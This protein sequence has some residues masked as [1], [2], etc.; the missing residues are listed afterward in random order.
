[1]DSPTSYS[2]SSLTADQ[3]AQI[4]AEAEACA[5]GYGV[6]SAQTMDGEAS[7]A[8][9]ARCL[10]SGNE[11]SRSLSF[12]KAIA[13]TEC[14]SNQLTAFEER[15]VKLQEVEQRNFELKMKEAGLGQNSL[16]AQYDVLLECSPEEV[17][18]QVLALYHNGF[19]C[20]EKDPHY[21]EYPYWRKLATV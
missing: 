20:Q 16:E 11:S 14:W 10:M 21:S 7:R 6:M 3:K 5:E 13:K 4:R 1:M 17:A 9:A 12:L 2:F 8:Y 18:T 15:K 19:A